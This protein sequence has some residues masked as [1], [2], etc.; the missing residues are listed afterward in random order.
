MNFIKFPKLLIK[1]FILNFKT[2]L[3]DIRWSVAFESIK[4]FIYAAKLSFK[5][6]MVYL[7]NI[8]NYFISVINPVIVLIVSAI[9]LIIIMIFLLEWSSMTLSISFS[10]F[11]LIMTFSMRVSLNVSNVV[12]SMYY[13]A[14][15][16]PSYYVKYFGIFFGVLIALFAHIKFAAP[17]HAGPILSKGLPDGATIAAVKFANSE[18][19]KTIIKLSSDIKADF[20]GTEFIK[21]LYHPK[22]ELSRDYWQT[23]LFEEG[24]I[25]FYDQTT[26]QIWRE[27]GLFYDQPQE[28]TRK[29]TS[30]ENECR[31]NDIYNKK[32]NKPSVES[33]RLLNARPGSGYDG[34]PAA[35]W[36][37]YKANP[38][39]ISTSIYKPTKT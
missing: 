20:N 26:E 3:S 34:Q 11:I 7:I 30:M 27:E 39:S 25:F 35:E 6:N 2:P 38:G 4:N 21:M 29:F 5:V 17:V 12:N 8:I 10:L 24:F 36:A 32:I 19:A 31:S 16:S 1:H 9:F 15:Y 22:L 37:K 23:G 28:K 14:R 33:M 18:T 13:Y